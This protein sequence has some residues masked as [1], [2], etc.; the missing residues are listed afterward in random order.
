MALQS[1]GEI[2][3]GNIRTE[4]GSSSG[5][6]RTLS[7]A[8]GKSTPDAMSE[9]YGYSSLIAFSSSTSST[10]TQVCPFNGSNLSLNQTYYHNGTTSDPATGNTCYSDANGTN[11]LSA[12]YYYIGGTGSGNR[13]YI[14][15]NSSGVVNSFG[16]QTC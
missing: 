4:I 13:K 9:F 11:T 3:I 14:E 5:S 12:G 2:S 10:F 6:L 8:A 16:V 1:S 15:L 7:S